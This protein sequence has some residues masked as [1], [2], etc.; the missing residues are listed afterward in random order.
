MNKEL[1]NTIIRKYYNNILNSKPTDKELKRKK[2]ID[3][4]AR[5]EK[6]DYENKRIAFYNNPLH[7]SNNKR[8]R[9]SLPALRGNTNK[10]RAKKYPSFRPTARFFCLLEDTI[11]DILS[12][13]FESNEFFE[14]FVDIKDMK[15]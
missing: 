13:K 12:D 14:K 5:Q 8:R 9:H 7:W 4:I 2:E 15:L 6:E 3:E 1:T 11:D 10:C